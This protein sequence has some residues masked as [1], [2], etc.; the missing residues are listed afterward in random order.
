MPALDLPP[1]PP[2]DGARHVHSGK[3]RDLY[4]IEVGPTRAGC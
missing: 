3:V 4:E 1:A 2:I